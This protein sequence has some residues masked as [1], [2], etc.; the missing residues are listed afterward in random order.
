MKGALILLCAYHTFFLNVSL[1]P[2]LQKALTSCVG[3]HAH[4]NL[5][6]HRSRVDS[7]G[8]AC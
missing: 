2:K 1:V 6:G 4:H 3:K 8:Y 5:L 7:L